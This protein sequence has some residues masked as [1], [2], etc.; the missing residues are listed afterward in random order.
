M[1]THY[2]SPPRVWRN[3]KEKDLISWLCGWLPEFWLAPFPWNCIRGQRVRA[4]CQTQIPQTSPTRL[5]VLNC[6]NWREH[7]KNFLFTVSDALQ[8]S[9]RWTLRQVAYQC[10]VITTLRATENIT[11]ME[12]W[13]SAFSHNSS[14]LLFLEY[15]VPS[16]ITSG[17]GGIAYIL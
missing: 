16:T 10:Q 5:S 6:I 12:A 14:L 8:F 9:T 4:H 3:F 11:E 17:V 15:S 1:G 2:T 13:S 7:C